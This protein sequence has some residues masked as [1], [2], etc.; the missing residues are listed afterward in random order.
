M[1]EEKLFLKIAKE[2]GNMIFMASTSNLRAHFG[3][4]IKWF[5]QSNVYF[6]PI[7]CD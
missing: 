6:W 4:I 5:N 7:H 3:N 2:E 1:S